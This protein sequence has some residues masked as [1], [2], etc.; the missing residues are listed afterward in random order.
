[1]STVD[2]RFSK[3]MPG[4]SNVWIYQVN[5]FEIQCF[6]SLRRQMRVKRV[7][8][9]W[10]LNFLGTFYRKLCG[11]IFYPPGLQHRAIFHWN[12]RT[13]P[14][15]ALALHQRHWESSGSLHEV[16]ER[17]HRAGDQAEDPESDDDE[18][19][20]EHPLA[21]A[22]PFLVEDDDLDDGGEHESQDGQTD[23]ADQGDHRAQ[24]G[25]RYG[26]QYWK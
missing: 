1:M 20:P 14:D 12:S 5:K 25:N 11:A 7:T 16:V 21:G 4:D 17:H 15:L 2:R 18:V 26:N 23:G 22:V 8:E 13:W 24:V 10:N 19:F 6:R 3:N 9:L